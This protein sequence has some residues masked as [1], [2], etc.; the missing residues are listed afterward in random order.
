MILWLLN[1]PPA[2][3]ATGRTLFPC[4]FIPES[5]WAEKAPKATLMAHSVGF[6][7]HPDKTLEWLFFHDLSYVC[8]MIRKHA[9]DSLKPAARARF[10][11]LVRRAKHLVIPGHCKHCS[12]PLARLACISYPS[13]GL[14][15]V[16]FFCDE[17][18]PETSHSPFVLMKPALLSPDFFLRYRKH[19]ETVLID[20]I[21]RRYFGRAARMTQAMM[22]E[23][24]DD[25]NNFVNP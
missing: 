3:S 8:W 7:K 12:M 22:E 4:V 1:G 6:K 23:F 20:A 24:F 15:E 11:Q 16:D 18:N 14:A 13:G 2:R 17:C 10:D 5:G 21:K 19:G 9:V 25:P